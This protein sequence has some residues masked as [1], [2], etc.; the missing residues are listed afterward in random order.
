MTLSMRN[1]NKEL[2]FKLVGDFL[3]KQYQPVQFIAHYKGKKWD[4]ET[5][6]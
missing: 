5:C 1:Y 2:D 6:N 3:V 4:L